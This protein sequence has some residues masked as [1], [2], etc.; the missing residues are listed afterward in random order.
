MPTLKPDTAA[1]VGIA[2][3][4]A[5]AW[6]INQA[7]ESRGKRRPLPLRVMGPNF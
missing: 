3:L 4:L 6:F 2:C 1:A 5:G 7:Y